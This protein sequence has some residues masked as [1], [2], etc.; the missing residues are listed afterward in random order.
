[1]EC[2]IAGLSIIP[3]RAEPASQSEMVSQLL[4]GETYQILEEKG[5]W[6]RIKGFSDQYEGWIN[7]LQHTLWSPSNELSGVLNNF[8]FTIATNIRT[9][10]EI[11]LMPGSI[12]HGFRYASDTLNFKMNQETYQIK[13][14]T[15]LLKPLTL[16]EV[17]ELG[18]KFLMAPYLW[19]GRT[20]WG[21][22]C[23]GFT[24]LI[25]KIAGLQ[26]PRDAWQQAEIGETIDFLNE[27]KLGDL[28][29]FDNENGRITH[30][31]IMNGQG[32]I[33]HASGKVRIDLID[34][35]GIFNESKGKHTHKLRT[36]K[37]MLN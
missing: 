11:Y 5:E 27:T 26:L 13:G 14:N 20:F 6:I 8:P 35:Y 1:M 36:I 37:R 33:L 34:S 29:F 32:E 28:A 2:G 10:K 24:Q 4:F 9:Q 19:G 3:V 7:A 31:G 16:S 17:L 21:I 18:R 22:D 25:Y 15:D 12:I 23:S 30:V